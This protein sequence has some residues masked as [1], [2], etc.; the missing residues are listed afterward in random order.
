M[1]RI[2]LTGWIV[3]GML[4]GIA[5]GVLAP[6]IARELTPLS[7]IFLRAVKAVI[8]PLIFGA[9]ISALAGAGSLQAI[10]RLGLRTFVYF[11]VVTTLALACGMLTALVMKPGFG[12]VLP[13]DKATADLPTTP[14]TFSAMLEQVVPNSLIDAMARGD[15]LQ[16]VVFCSV[17][18][19]A[20]AALGA[21]AKPVVVFAEALAEVMFRVTSYAMWLA[22]LGVGA[23]VAV[24]IGNGG[25]GA[26]SALW[27]VVLT[28]YLA[29]LLFTLL[30]LLPLFVWARVSW[31]QF[32]QAMREPFL[33]AVA[34]T[35][36]GVALPLLLENL[37]RMGVPKRITG[38][39]LPAC[40]CFNLTGTTLYIPIA[41]L[42][43]AQAAGV[44]LSAGQLALLFL[45]LMITSKGA[46]AVPRSSLLI[47][48]G[49]L[50]SLRLPVE[51][52]ALL[53]S[54][55]IAMDMV[56]TAVNILGHGVAPLVIARWE[57]AAAPAAE[58]PPAEIEPS[59]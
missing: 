11:W 4:A 43:T 44:M 6:S 41:V 34:T 55:E 48:L 58:L 35:S 45:M 42:F 15:V 54:A 49:T 29:L 40:F 24:T 39:V 13:T 37:E 20:C 16:I 5:V 2:T 51:G 25:L 53:L 8:A 52:V 21:R 17:F 22:P 30:A 27:R 1:K 56:R 32:Y 26:L 28:L 19:L 31:R 18:G 38:F 33:L 9:L 46:P 14:L 59:A 12:I 7:N 23:A 36:S 10:G 50:N 3:I 47:I 57:E